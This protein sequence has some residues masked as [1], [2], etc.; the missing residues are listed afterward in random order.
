MSVESA[1]TTAARVLVSIRWRSVARGISIIL[2]E[3][4]PALFCG[5]CAKETLLLDRTR[6]LL[7]DF[8]ELDNATIFTGLDREVSVFNRILGGC[9]VL[10]RLL[11]EIIDS[12][13]QFLVL[14]LQF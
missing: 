3:L 10:L 4:A 11:L 6:L 13:L 1:T 2:F 8:A 12:L 14:M 7:G 5:D 9:G